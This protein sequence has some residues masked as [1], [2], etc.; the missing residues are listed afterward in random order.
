MIKRD[1]Q[2]LEQDFKDSKRI[3]QSKLYA[4]PGSPEE[5]P[6]IKAPVKIVFLQSAGYFHHN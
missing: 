3:C 1:N 5:R 6:D 2:S 4:W